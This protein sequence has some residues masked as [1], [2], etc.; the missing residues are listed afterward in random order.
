MQIFAFTSENP[1]SRP[2]FFEGALIQSGHENLYA[3]KVE[4]YGT[5]DF[6]DPQS[7]DLVKPRGKRAFTIVNVCHDQIHKVKIGAI[8]RCLLVTMAVLLDDGT[9]I[10][11]PDNKLFHPSTKSFVTIKKTAYDSVEKTAINF[12]N[13]M[14]RQVTFD[15]ERD[16]HS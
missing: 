10:V 13:T 9:V 4:I 3:L 8:K 1:C 12:Y 5:T 15:P 7:Q 16:E 11:G 6:E 14:A 2:K